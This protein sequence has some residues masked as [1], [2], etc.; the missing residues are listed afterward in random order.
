MKKKNPTID[1]LIE[2]ISLYKDAPQEWPRGYENE[3]I[4]EVLRIGEQKAQDELYQI[5]KKVR[6]DKP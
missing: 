1:R 6:G 5:L 3:H 2:T 4:S